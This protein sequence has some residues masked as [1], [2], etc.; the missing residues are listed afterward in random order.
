MVRK[1]DWMAQRGTWLIFDEDAYHGPEPLEGVYRIA[2]IGGRP[3]VPGNFL[4]S[5]AVG[6]I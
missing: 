2:F 3:K 4:A 6:P 1:C 5:R